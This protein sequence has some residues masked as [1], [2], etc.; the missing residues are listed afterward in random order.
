[1]GLKETLEEQKEQLEEALKAESTSV[2][3]V[4]EEK[5]IEK[6]EEKPVEDMLKE[7]AA[8]EEASKEESKVEETKKT[9]AE[10]AAERRAN[11]V[12]MAAELATANARIAALE[13]QNKEAPKKEQEPNKEEDPQAWTE[14]Q[15]RK[16][17]ETLGKVVEI[18]AKTEQERHNERMR[19]QAF[20]EVAAFE[21]TVRTANPDYDQA[22]SFYANTIAYSIKKLN[23][24]ITNERL[25]EA[26]N[27]KMLVRASEFLNEGYDN[28]I[29][30]MYNESKEWGFTPKK[31][32]EGKEEKP[33]IKPDLA[34]V[35][36]NRA[37]NAGTAGAQGDSGRSELTPA[38]AMG[39]TNAEFS[40]LKP[41][42]KESIFKQLRAMA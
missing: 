16:T 23:P 39:L 14:H 11:K 34:K 32:D 6:P 30:A 33:E 19:N 2:E 13:A 1:M 10:Y 20:N 41:A 5:E 25:V 37:R 15:L 26:V 40:K 24:K 31:A 42:E 38:V 22:K 29:E 8:K 9:P 4:K 3:E 35:S 7:E 18:T 21:A 17:Q 28:P 12:S 27:N 36:A